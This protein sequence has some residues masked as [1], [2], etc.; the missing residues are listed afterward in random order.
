[1]SSPSSRATHLSHGAP[2]RTPRVTS[3]YTALGTCP[4]CHRRSTAKNTTHQG[5]SV[6]LTCHDNNVPATAAQHRQHCER[7]HAKVVSDGHTTP[8]QATGSR[9]RQQRCIVCSSAGQLVTS[10]RGGCGGPLAFHH[11]DL[12]SQTA[13]RQT[14]LVLV[15]DHHHQVEGW[16]GVSA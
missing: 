4:S 8:K 9:A 12:V 1:M 3:P 15:L 14:H 5:N 7:A 13:L 2:A 11:I 6:C 16:V 10:E